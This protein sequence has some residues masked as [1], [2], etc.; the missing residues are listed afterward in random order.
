[1]RRP[2]LVEKTVK[3]KNRL[4]NR[5]YFKINNKFYVFKRQKISVLHYFMLYYL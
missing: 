3:L 2:A 5:N 1:M 4:Y